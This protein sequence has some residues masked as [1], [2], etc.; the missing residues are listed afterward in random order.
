MHQNK[1]PGGCLYITSSCLMS[2]YTCLSVLAGSVCIS[3]L[4]VVGLEQFW[5]G[6][7]A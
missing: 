1:D 3:Q 2:P 6:L 5:E 4:Y 7:S